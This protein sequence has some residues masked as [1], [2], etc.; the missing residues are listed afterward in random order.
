MRDVLGTLTAKGN[1]RR[2]SPVAEEVQRGKKL[3]WDVES[4]R[5]LPTC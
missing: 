3:T 5:P 1:P 4:L 2:S